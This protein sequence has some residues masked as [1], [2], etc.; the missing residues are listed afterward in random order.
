MFIFVNQFGVDPSAYAAF[1]NYT[2]TQ[3]RPANNIIGLTYADILSST[4]REAIFALLVIIMV[5]FVIIV[6]LLFYTGYTS[7]AY[8]VLAIVVALGVLGMYY[9]LGAS[10]ALDVGVK[11]APLAQESL[12]KSTAYTANATIRDAIYLTV[13]R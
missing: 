11:S 4:T 9:A 3:T 12:F 6:V 13:C 10:Y 7:L 1:V 8:L 5:T 2:L